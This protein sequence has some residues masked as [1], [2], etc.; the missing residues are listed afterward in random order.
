MTRFWFHSPM[1]WVIFIE[2][3]FLVSHTQSY[4]Q[5]MH[6]NWSWRIWKLLTSN[7]YQNSKFPLNILH[8]VTRF[9]TIF[10]VFFP[11]IILFRWSEVMYVQ[12]AV[13][14][15]GL[16]WKLQKGYGL[17]QI[18]CFLKIYTK[19]LDIFQSN[20]LL[21]ELICFKFLISPIWYQI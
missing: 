1:V 18:A 11:T 6:A 2:L 8:N 16:S 7:F 21:A 5:L 20:L 12:R 13:T 14:Q 9:Y 17:F 15:I 3:K 19:I 10:L 4:R